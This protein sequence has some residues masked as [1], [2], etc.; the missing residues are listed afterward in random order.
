MPTYRHLLAGTALAAALVLAGVTASVSAQRLDRMQSRQG[1][2]SATE[3]GAGVQPSAAAPV[4]FGAWGFDITGVD[5]KAKPGDSFYE[6][7]NG[8]WDTRT[9][10]PSD[11]SRFGLFD[12]LTDRTQDEL[13]A[14]IE[15]AAGSGTPGD[16]ERGK[17]GAL[18]NSF[19]DEAG[20]ETLDAA[21]IAPDLAAIRDAKTRADF[22]VLMGRSKRG[23]GQ[24]LFFLGISEDAKHPTRNTLT[25]FQGRWACPTATII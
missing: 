13:R 11:R 24:T 16:S 19:M 4:H 8:V 18:F 25:V 20:A 17:I 6:Y 21:P 12:L 5:Q 10:I 15:D 3:A 2:A 1:A 14:I 7:A 9:S 23:F 22:A